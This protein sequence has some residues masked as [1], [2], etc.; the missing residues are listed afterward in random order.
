MRLFSLLFHGAPRRPQH[1]QRHGDKAG[2][3]TLS[4]RYFVS[5]RKCNV[6]IVSVSGYDVTK[7]LTISTLNRME[8]FCRIIVY[9]FFF[10]PP[11]IIV[12]NEV[13]NDSLMEKNQTLEKDLVTD[14]VAYIRSPP[15][16]YLRHSWNRVDFLSIIGYWVDLILLLSNEEIVGDSQRILVFKMLSAIR[17]LRLLN[18]TNGNKIILHSLKKSAPLLV[19]VMFFV[20]FFFVIF[21]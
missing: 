21:G 9:G 8:M 16:A 1:H 11:P 17:L 12:S 15:N 6:P 19:N 14:G 18:V 5:T 3:N 20:C 4:W 2:I 10:N 13:D 7:V